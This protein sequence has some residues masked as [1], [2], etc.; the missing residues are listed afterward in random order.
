MCYLLPPDRG[1]REHYMICTWP[2][3]PVIAHEIEGLH[4]TVVLRLFLGDNIEAREEHGSELPVLILD[5]VVHRSN[6]LEPF[7]RL[8]V[9]HPHGHTIRAYIRNNQRG[10]F[11]RCRDCA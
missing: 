8:F 3:D 6:G 10:Y 1:R 7:R 5:G 2:P 11:R 9:T 4:L